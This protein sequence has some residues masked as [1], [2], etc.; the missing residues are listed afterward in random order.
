MGAFRMGLVGH[1][2]RAQLGPVTVSWAQDLQLASTHCTA[3]AA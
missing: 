2:Y 3:K 1:V